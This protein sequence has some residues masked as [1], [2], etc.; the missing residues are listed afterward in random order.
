MGIP[1]SISVQKQPFKMASHSRKLRQRSNSERWQIISTEEKRMKEMYFSILHY[2]LI[3]STQ[4]DIRN[5]K[6]SFRR[7]EGAKEVYKK[8]HHTREAKSWR[9]TIIAIVTLSANWKAH[10][11]HLN[12]LDCGVDVLL[13]NKAS[14]NVM[15]IQIKY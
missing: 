1:P 7:R 10:S 13:N 6:N 9:C 4:Q 8:L 11:A 2:S 3:P 15:L 5:T 14:R 12:Q